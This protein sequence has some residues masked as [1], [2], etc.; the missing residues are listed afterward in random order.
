[1]AISVQ[2]AQHFDPEA[3]DALV[4]RHG[5]PTLWRRA[6]TC[7][8]LSADTG[9]PRIV[10]PFCVDMPGILWDAGTDIKILAAGRSRRD[11]HE[12]FGL[13]LQGFTSFSFPS[14]VTPGHLDRIDLL[15]GRMVI[16]DE[17]HVRGDLDKA[18]RSRERLR[19]Y[20]AYSVEF[21]EAIIGTDLVQ[22]TVGT[23]FAVDLAGDILWVD[24]RGPA[25]GGQYTMRY[26]VRPTFVCWSPISRDEYGNKQPY[27]VTVQRLDFFTRKAV[28]E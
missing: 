26:V 1:M 11:D 13:R 24:G 7:P 22:Y 12:D 3:F 25:E 20:P 14:T 8:C 16:N 23:D 6:R 21:C 10:C 17:R 15:A 5:T 19:V 2:T 4:E 27:R 28:G 18:G 9:A